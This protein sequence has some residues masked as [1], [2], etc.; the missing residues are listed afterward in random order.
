VGI[1]R[2]PITFSKQLGSFPIVVSLDF[3]H[4]EEEGNAGFQSEDPTRKD[5]NMTAPDRLRPFKAHR[6]TQLR[7]RSIIVDGRQHAPNP[8]RIFQPI[9]FPPLSLLQP[10]DS[11]DKKS[12]RDRTDQSAE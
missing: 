12:N 2:N 11:L 10:L 8:K 9:G 5:N 4:E 6:Q 1:H 7:L 3:T